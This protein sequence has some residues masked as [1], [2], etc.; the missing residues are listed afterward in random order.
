[1]IFLVCSW[2]F[3]VFLGAADLVMI[4]RVY[5][6]WSRSRTI[7]GILLFFYVVQIIAAFV[8][9]GIYNNP[10]TYF[11]A[12]VAEVLDFAYCNYMAGGTIST[13]LYFTIPRFVLS[14]VLFALAVTQ[15]LK[16]LIV[17]YRAT[18]VWQPN[19]FMEQLVRDGIFYFT[20]N[21]VFNIA[22]ALEFQPNWND[23]LI[24]LLNV[25][26]F[27]ALCPLVPRFILSLRELYDCDI[28]GRWGGIDTAF[29]GSSQPLSSR[30]VAASAIAF[31]GI[32]LDED[33]AVE[34]RADDLEAI[35]LRAVGNPARQV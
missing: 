3:P 5:T 26:S 21:V 16:Q 34:G 8:Y 22:V 17:F 24:L 9:T 10:D 15:T 11:S 33:P 28:D 35:R 29:G 7:L 25:L 20:M 1:V 12:T 4:L 13:D 32:S 18:K 6:V 30:D 2:A 14:V 23:I 19:Q 31:A 27:I